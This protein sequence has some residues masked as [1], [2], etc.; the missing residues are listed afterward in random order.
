MKDLYALII[1]E[2]GRNYEVRE[3]L[4]Y[5]D[6]KPFYVGS[7]TL[8]QAGNTRV[9]YRVHLDEREGR[10]LD[11]IVPESAR[12][13][14]TGRKLVTLAERRFHFHGVAKVAGYADPEVHDFW[15]RLGYTILPNNDILKHLQ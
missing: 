10:I 9:S 2:D 13:Q 6:I 3:D 4:Y 8:T 12:R 5:P 1:S 11:V 14:G 7:I 15:R